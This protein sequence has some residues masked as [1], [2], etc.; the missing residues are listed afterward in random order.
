MSFFPVRAVDRPRAQEAPNIA[1]REPTRPQR[2]P[3]DSPRRP[4]DGAP[5]P[6]IRGQQN[7]R[8]RAT[9]GR[10]QVTT[11]AGAPSGP[12]IRAQPGGKR[13]F[14][15]RHQVTTRAGAPSGPHIRGDTRLQRGPAPPPGHISGATPGYDE[16]RG[17]L[18]ATYQGRH[19]VTTRA[20][21]PLWVAPAVRSCARVYIY[22]NKWHVRAQAHTKSCM[23]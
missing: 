16:G 22:I 6:H 17:P 7:M 12:H 19:Q 13:A 18:R 11:R 1:S 14:A 15:G 3:Q 23:M 20:G 5:R 21:T 8:K 10:H 4:Q 9:G 2:R